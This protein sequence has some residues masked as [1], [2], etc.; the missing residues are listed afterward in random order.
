[1]KECL[2]EFMYL[3]VLVSLCFSGQKVDMI[4]VNLRVSDLGIL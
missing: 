4:S 1:M 3:Y 2:K